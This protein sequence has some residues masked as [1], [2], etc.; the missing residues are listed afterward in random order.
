MNEEAL[1]VLTGI[2]MCAGIVRKRLTALRGE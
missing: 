1:T 2:D